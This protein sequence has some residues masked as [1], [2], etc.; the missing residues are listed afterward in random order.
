[1][2][3]AAYEG[4]VDRIRGLLKAGADVNAREEA[5]WTALHMAVV[6]GE[7]AV[8]R[9]LLDAGAYVNAKTKYGETV[10]GLARLVAADRWPDRVE[11][12]ELVKARGGE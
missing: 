12:M 3:D 4:E 9:M 1:M 10:L 2:C 11:V 5:G 8:I 6:G 7:A